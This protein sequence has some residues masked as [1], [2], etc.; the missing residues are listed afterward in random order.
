VNKII[1]YELNEVSWKV[2]DFYINKR[3]NSNIE[4]LLKS[5]NLFTS[6][7][8][9]SGE[10]HPWSTWPTMHRGVTNDI[11]DIRFINQDL[12]YSTNFPPIWELIVNANKSIGIFGSLQTGH[13]F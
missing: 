2:I 5:S 3:S 4:K 8:K 12:S 7:T 6:Q 9:D 1:S 13:T 10:L 11:H